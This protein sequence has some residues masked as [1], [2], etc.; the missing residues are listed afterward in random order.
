MIALFS[1]QF[2]FG[3]QMTSSVFIQK[4]LTN[5]F[6]EWVFLAL[7]VVVVAS[8]V[9]CGG[10]GTGN[11]STSLNTNITSIVE[12]R[13]IKGP[14]A[15]ANVQAFAVDRD[16]V[17]SV[18]PLA[19]TVTNA[20]GFYRLNLGAYHGALQVV[21]TMRSDS[22]MRDEAIGAHITPPA[23]LRFRALTLVDAPLGKSNSNKDLQQ[24]QTITV[25]PFTELAAIVANKFGEGKLTANHVR[26]SLEAVRDVLGFDPVA[27]PGVESTDVA[28][29]NVSP[30][31][32]KN[33]LALAAVSWIAKHGT[34]ED[35]LTQSCLQ[36]AAQD[37]AKRLSCA[38]ALIERILSV[39]PLTATVEP[40]RA[41]LAFSKAIRQVDEDQQINKTAMTLSLAPAIIELEQR[42]SPNQP[43][44]VAV[45]YNGSGMSGTTAAKRLLENLRSNGDAIDFGMNQEG[46]T[47]SL[48][49]LGRS[50]DRAGRMALDVG[51][52]IDMINDGIVFWND[53]R[54][55]LKASSSFNTLPIPAYGNPGYAAC[56]VYS[57]FIPNN[58]LDANF[59]GA[60]A[61][62]YPYILLSPTASQLKTTT[63]ARQ[64]DP[65]LIVDPTNIPAARPSD[66][67]WLGCSRYS[68]EVSSYVAA[69]YGTGTELNTRTRYRQTLRLRVDAQ[70]A[71]GRP[72]RVSYIA[73]SIKQYSQPYSAS[74]SWLVSRSVNLLESPLQG[75]IEL[76]WV[77]Q[78]ITSARIVGDL[79]PS[80]DHTSVRFANGIYASRDNLQ[81]NRYSADAHV[82]FIYN[83]TNTTIN[84]PKISLELVPVGARTP[85][86]T[87]EINP[88]SQTSYLIAPKALD[89]SGISSIRLNMSA[90]VT[91]PDG[92]FNGTIEALSPPD[93]GSTDEPVNGS[94]MFSGELSA[95]NK[96]G[97]LLEVGNASLKVTAADRAPTVL[98]K[99]RLY[100]P[101]RE[102]LDLQL[103]VSQTQATSTVPGSVNA[104]LSYKQGNFSLNFTGIEQENYLS[105]RTGTFFSMNGSGGI[106]ASWIDG[107]RTIYL[108]ENGKSI[109][110]ID[111]RTGRV[112][113]NDG[114]F[115]IIR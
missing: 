35:P 30:D 20:E 68:R 23:E 105:A 38:L 11:G 92:R 32:R 75:A 24:V 112:L 37:S 40:R 69:T 22:T 62:D 101:A 46:I 86:L 13:V 14:I 12:G 78:R 19:E 18:I 36:L 45:S 49:G 77:G 6:F 93:C 83:D 64:N 110:E 47:A 9:S 3:M 61:K 66:A 17:V 34:S 60:V 51:S 88:D 42:A 59:F 29:A 102:P 103:S 52:L 72:T 50:L 28:A 74:D 54:A 43:S 115:Q 96:L 91:A 8:L 31:S 25:S 5:K 67:R 85:E 79:P 15:Q 44:I 70:D 63:A 10:S 82:S 106:S 113:F 90:K 94:F 55:G 73:M 33:G 97:K 87:F 57:S 95:K 16:G 65:R 48:T 21:A 104:Q 84:L 114:S 7:F 100:V 89:C 76:A 108:K 2:R 56:A 71:A 26:G 39:E 58:L 111:T 41:A 81:A 98:L 27:T 1:A 80:V 53:Y 109:G 107:D 4:N 99:G